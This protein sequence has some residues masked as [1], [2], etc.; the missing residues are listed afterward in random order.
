MDAVV[1]GGLGHGTN[2]SSKAA[3]AATPAGPPGSAAAGAA[4]GSEASAARPGGIDIGC[5]Q[6]VIKP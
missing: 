5:F 6:F 2:A 1:V 3:R 4:A